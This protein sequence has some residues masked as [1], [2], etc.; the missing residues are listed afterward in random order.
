[1]LVHSTYPYNRPSP[2]KMPIA[3][4]VRARLPQCWSHQCGTTTAMYEWLHASHVCVSRRCSYIRA[5]N[6][7]TIEARMFHATLLVLVSRKW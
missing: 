4:A 5:N 2:R 1:M 7:R 6:S 3:P